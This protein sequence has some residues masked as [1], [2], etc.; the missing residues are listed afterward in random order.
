MMCPGRLVR[1]GESDTAVVAALQAALNEALV[2]HDATALAVA[3]PSQSS[4]EPGHGGGSQAV[5]GTLCGCHG[6]AT[7]G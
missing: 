5:S 6:Y 4:H 7:Q 2:L 1:F 3:Q